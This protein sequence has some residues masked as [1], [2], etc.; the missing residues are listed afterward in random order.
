MTCSFTL[1]SYTSLL[2]SHFQEKETYIRVKLLDHN[3]SY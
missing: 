2:D 3:G 1:S